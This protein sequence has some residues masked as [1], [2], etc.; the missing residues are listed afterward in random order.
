[1]LPERIFFVTSGGGYLMLRASVWFLA[2][3]IILTGSLMTTAQGVK[4]KSTEKDKKVG[5]ISKEAI[6]A[7]I[8]KMDVKKGT[9]T[10]KM[11]DKDGKDVEKNF[12]LT[13]DVLMMDDT[14]HIVAIDVFESGNDVLVLERE[15]RLREM[16][17]QH[18][19]KTGE[20]KEKK[21]S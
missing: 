4:D 6:K 10:L 13:E 9:I 18:K 15:G 17:Q 14:G 12:K 5:K 3:V 7:T 21:S 1:M 19:G 8:T 11:K 16:Q 20:T 2:A